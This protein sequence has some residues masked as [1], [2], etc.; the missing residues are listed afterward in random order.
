M[1]P[2]NE[3]FTQTPNDTDTALQAAATAAGEA[4][5]TD[6]EKFDARYGV[7]E[8]IKGEVDGLL[9]FD[10]NGRLVQ[11]DPEYQGT[12]K[13][14]DDA[15]EREE[16]L[17]GGEAAPTRQPSFTE[18]ADGADPAGVDASE[19]TEDTDKTI[20]EEDLPPPS[21]NGDVRH[22]NFKGGMDILR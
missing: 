22:V 10:E 6:R 2:E 1:L 19:A 16:A 12:L 18:Q 20:A 3:D 4:T 17:H 7:D 5:T 9:L 14:L 13:P 15:Q 21:A 11:I 8:R